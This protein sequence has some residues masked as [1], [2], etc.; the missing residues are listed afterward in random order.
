MIF[1]FYMKYYHGVVVNLIRENKTL[2]T[3][4]S[5]Y[6]NINFAEKII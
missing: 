6:S 2:T 1:I 3:S 4:Q 5:Q